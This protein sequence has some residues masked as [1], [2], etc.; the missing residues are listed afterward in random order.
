MSATSIDLSQIKTDALSA[1]STFR[2]L[3]GLGTTD[4]PTFKGAILA[5][6][7]IT[8]STP[9]IDISQTWNN[10]AV[11][12]TGMKFNAV[13]TAS[14]A[15]SLL[16]DLQV[17]GT[18][19]FKVSKSGS[20]TG[21][22]ATLSSNVIL[23]GYISAGASANM[24]ISCDHTFAS[25]A[26]GANGNSGSIVDVT[27]NSGH[28]G[29]L[30]SWTRAGT[31]VS[32]VGTTGSL[33]VYN[34]ND[35]GSNYE[36]A[37][38]AWES[39]VLWFGY[40]YGGT[41]NLYRQTRLGGSTGYFEQSSNQGLNATWGS[42]GGNF[43]RT[44]WLN[45]NIQFSVGGVTN[46]VGLNTS[47]SNRFTLADTVNIEFNTTT[48]TKIGTGTTQKLGFWN[49]TPIVQPAAVADATDAASVITQLNDLLSK[50][51]TLGLIAT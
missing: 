19:K 44:Q 42:A 34:A 11:T 45:G 41:G 16:M 48:G 6:G 22:A 32:S 39:N 7:T 3:I 49:A 37:K 28:T 46:F 14:S 25:R 15:S 38:I 51:R 27:S 36:R 17:G 8:A 29:L 10:A 43:S 5:T 31:I 4:T 50:L 30:Q 47:G 20:L 24:L 1:A 13:D 40:E 35:N 9:A 18:S 23:S 12:F 21:N 26:T 33:F 2:T